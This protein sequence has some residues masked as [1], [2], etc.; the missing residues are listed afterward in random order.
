MMSGSRPLAAEQG[1]AL[2]DEHVEVTPQH[3][4][5]QIA[6]GTGRDAP[7]GR[8]VAEFLDRLGVV[9]GDLRIGDLAGQQIHLA[10]P[11]V[12]GQGR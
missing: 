10:D 6:A 5:A 3:L 12:P 8:A 11:R 4:L 2:V 9:G 7:D 1:E